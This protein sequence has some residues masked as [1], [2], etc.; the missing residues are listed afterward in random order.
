MKYRLNLGILLASALAFTITSHA[1]PLPTSGAVSNVK[2]VFTLKTSVDGTFERDENGK[3]VKDDETNE[4]IPTDLNSWSVTRGT[5]TVDTTEEVVKIVT[6]KYGN[7]ELLQDLL[8]E[9]VIS[10][11]SIQGWTLKMV[12]RGDSDPAFFAEKKGVPPVELSDLIGFGPIEGDFA[13]VESINRLETETST[14]G[15][16]ESVV[17]LKEVTTRQSFWTFTININ[18]GTGLSTYGG[19]TEAGKVV[20]SKNKV[21]VVVPTISM[22]HLAGQFEIDEDEFF[23][24]GSFS[25]SGSSV[26]D[27]LTPYFPVNVQ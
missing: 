3:F 12:S 24:E 6:F 21:P 8:D 23:A 14:E 15:A 16:E 10:G 4:R 22:P 2:L 27:D 5:K 9:E 26:T 7:R 17:K 13:T 20:Y 1:I 19:A 18:D 11:E 25:V